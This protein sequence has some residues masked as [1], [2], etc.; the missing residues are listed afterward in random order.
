VDPAN[1]LTLFINSSG[2]ALWAFIGFVIVDV[3]FG[4]VN[5]LRSGTFSFNYLPNFL[6]S[7]L[8]IKYAV[9]VLSAVLANTQSPSSM[10]DAAL[11]LVTAGSGAMILSLLRDIVVKINEIRNFKKSTS[12]SVPVT[13]NTTNPATVTSTK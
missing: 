12:V 11:G 13:Q 3:L 5:P 1:L 7:S 9:I 2:Y 8:G 4:I 10:R 6:N